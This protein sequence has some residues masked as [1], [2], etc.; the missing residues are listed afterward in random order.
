MTDK[1]LAAMLYQIALLVHNATE[2]LKNTLALQHD[3]EDLA[4]FA[5]LN[6]IAEGLQS[7][8]DALVYIVPAS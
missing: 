3:I 6:K 7:Q 1:Q 8:A 2:H 5:D 4:C